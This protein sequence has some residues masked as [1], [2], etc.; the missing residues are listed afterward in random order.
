L[1]HLTTFD[2][3]LRAAYR[4]WPCEVLPNALWKTL[5]AL[6]RTID[7][8]L[9]SDVDAATGEV[10]FLQARDG[11]QLMVHWARSGTLPLPDRR[12]MAAF[13]LA[14]V[15]ERH[16]ASGRFPAEDLTSVR[17]YFRLVHRGAAAPFDLGDGLALRNVDNP[18]EV[19]D[20]AA[21]INRCYVDMA[22]AP[23][24]VRTWMDHPVYA[25]DLWVWAVD[26][27]TITP[28]GL[29]IA[30]LDPTVPEASLEWVQ[31]LPAYRRRRIG[32]VIVSELLRRVEGRVV[33]TT[34]SGELDN[35]TNPEALYRRCGFTGDDV[36]WVLRR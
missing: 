27:D 32:T 16:I 8:V 9:V 34:V 18:H 36:W 2:A 22:L 7:P 6:R 17:R 26:L 35:T 4:E 5:G 19:A 11:E 3:A 24:T 15:N 30:E 13:R 21:F 28:V 23:E 1:R 12:W 29:G 25:P 31:V 20:V 33:F 14:L 10:Q